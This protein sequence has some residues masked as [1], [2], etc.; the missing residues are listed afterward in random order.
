MLFLE[1]CGK[2]YIA[3][4]SFKRKRYFFDSKKR[5]CIRTDPGCTTLLH[6]F[7]DCMRCVR[8]NLKE[9]K[10]AKA[11]EALK[12]QE[13]LKNKKPKKKLWIED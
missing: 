8:S 7:G 1:H 10:R 11:S 4:Y 5:G 2:T 9:F 13:K 6:T 12:K 3:S